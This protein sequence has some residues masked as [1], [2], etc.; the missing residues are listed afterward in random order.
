MRI[1]T[2]I[3]QVIEKGRRVIKFRGYGRNDTATSY[4][5]A[6]FG[7]DYIPPKDAKMVQIRSTNSQDSVIV[8][9]VNKAD[10]S[11]AEGEKVIYSTNANGEV[12][13][14]IYLRNDGKIE[15]KGTSVEFLE[16]TDNA[17]RYSKLESEFNEL[18]S[19]WN[20]FAAAYVPGGPTVVGTPPTAQQSAADITQAKVDEIKLP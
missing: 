13:A 18:K 10:E 15:V 2:Y 11:L 7:T 16:G 20:A 8:C 6:T 1:V 3:S 14:Q 9:M 17:V 12:Q 19:K 5:G 4:L